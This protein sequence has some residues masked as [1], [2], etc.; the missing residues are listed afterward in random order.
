M[1]ADA[2]DDSS[3]EPSVDDEEHQADD[4]FE[5]RRDGVLCRTNGSGEHV[6]HPSEEA[7]DQHDPQRHDERAI[8]IAG[9]PAESTWGSEAADCQQGSVE[10]G[11]DCQLEDQQRQE[12]P[13]EH[14]DDQ[15]DVLAS[16]RVPSLSQQRQEQ[17]AE[18]DGYGDPEQE[19]ERFED[20]KH[21]C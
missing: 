4:A 1:H 3:E 2:D 19:L 9:H 14:Q 20:V 11:R 21:D 18:H 8:D 6:A 10:S 13:A 5:E 17:E 12:W 15:S 16:P 7:N